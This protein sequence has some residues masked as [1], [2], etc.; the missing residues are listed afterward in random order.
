MLEGLQRTI[1]ANKPIIIFE[2]DEN[3]CISRGKK[4]FADFYNFFT[5][6][7]YQLYNINEIG[8][9][10]LKSNSQKIEANILALPSL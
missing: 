5:P 8:A 7:G 2:Y 4:S 9:T 10:L 3:Y 6:L 1:T